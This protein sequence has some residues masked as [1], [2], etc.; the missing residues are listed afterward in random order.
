M[1]VPE[2]C[3]VRVTYAA[4]LKEKL[5]LKSQDVVDAVWKSRHRADAAAD[6]FRDCE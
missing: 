4:I 5:T 2:V 1:C 6:E 3:D